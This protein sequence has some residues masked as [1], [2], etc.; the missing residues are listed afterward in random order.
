MF[1]QTDFSQEHV[2]KEFSVLESLVASGRWD[3]SVEQH[4][5]GL[6]EVHTILK[7]GYSGSPEHTRLQKLAGIYSAIEYLSNRKTGSN[8]LSRIISEYV[9]QY[10]ASSMTMFRN[11][12]E[13]DMAAKNTI[14]E[15][16]L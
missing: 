15:R 5:C 12:P 8:I 13:A 3:H 10:P 11:Q 14:S 7:N 9:L 1:C 16:C 4:L 6:F 2:D